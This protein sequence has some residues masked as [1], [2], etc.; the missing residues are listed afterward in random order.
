MAGQDNL[1]GYTCAPVRWNAVSSSLMR[2]L[3]VISLKKGEDRRLR[4]GH[5]WVFSN[6]VDVG[7][8]PLTDLVAGQVANVVDAAGRPVGTALVNPRSLI[9]ARL[10]SRR[11]DVEPSVEWFLARLRSALAM[12]ERIFAQPFYRLVFGESDGLP[13]LFV[14]PHSGRFTYL[15]IPLPWTGSSLP[16]CY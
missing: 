5:L 16:I 9:C 8:T 10:I 1:I 12:R 11:P 7:A 14:N 4:A 6:E 3:D 13:G 2:T 15:M